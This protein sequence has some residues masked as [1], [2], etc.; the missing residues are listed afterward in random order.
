MWI[1]SHTGI[2]AVNIDVALEA[3]KRGMRVILD[4]V[5]SHTGVDS[6]Y[7]DKAGRYGGTG[8]YQSKDSPYYKRIMKATER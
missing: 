6:R 3:K 7:F 8:A 5:F 2:N 1:F 4:G